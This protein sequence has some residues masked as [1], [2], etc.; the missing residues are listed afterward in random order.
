MTHLSV[1]KKVGGLGKHTMSAAEVNTVD[2]HLH[3]GRAAKEEGTRP[4]P[5][6]PDG[7][8]GRHGADVREDLAAGSSRSDG[9]RTLIVTG[10]RPVGLPQLPPVT[11]LRSCWHVFECG[12]QGSASC[13]R[14]SRAAM[15]VCVSDT[16]VEPIRS[17]TAGRRCP[18]LNSP[19][20]AAEYLEARHLERFD[21]LRQIDA[22]LSSG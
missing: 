15:A 4:R 10:L 6:Q 8:R 12:L 5:C 17:S 16:R 19:R 21:A 1:P 7:D 20:V 3:H 9:W 18:S 11:G 14:A 22:E 2:G 13:A